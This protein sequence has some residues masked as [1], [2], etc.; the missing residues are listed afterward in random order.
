AAGLALLTAGRDGP[1][2]L[3]EAHRR[4]EPPYTA[5]AEARA[6]GATALL[7][8]SDGLVQD[9]GHIAAASGVRID[10]RTAELPVPEILGPDGLHHV[11]TGGEDHGFA[12][13]FPANAVLPPSWTPVGTVGEGAGVFVDGRVPAAG[14]WDHFPG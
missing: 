6:A 10:V 12:G 14:G 8:V 2:E 1:A 3:L 11:L 9:L 4:P 7:D 13:T 5:G